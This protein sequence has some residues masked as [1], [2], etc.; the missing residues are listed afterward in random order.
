M[1]RMRRT[2]FTLILAGAPRAALA[3]PVCFGQSDEPMAKAMNL[4]IMLM[5]VVVVA[6]L[7][8]FASFIVSLARRER[9]AGAASTAARPKPQEGTVQC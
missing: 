8:G 3:C 5:L 6:V 9:L 7:G 4:G 1:S 2:L